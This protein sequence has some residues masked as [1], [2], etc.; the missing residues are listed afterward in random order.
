VLR[1]RNVDVMRLSAEHHHSFVRLFLPILHKYLLSLFSNRAPAT[2]DF[3]KRR[4]AVAPQ[5]GGHGVRQ[6][7]GNPLADVV[8]KT[9]KSGWF[10][11]SAA[12]P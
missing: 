11:G 4:V 9:T 3:K 6:P 8:R 7:A 2:P 5:W 12:P 1:E 10:L